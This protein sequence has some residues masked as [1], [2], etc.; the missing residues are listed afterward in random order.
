MTQSALEIGRR[1][2]PSDWKHLLVL[3]VPIFGAMGPYLLP[4]EVAGVNLFA[5][6]ALV[7]VT[8]YLTF[9]ANRGQGLVLDRQSRPFFVLGALW[10]CWAVASYFWSVDQDNAIRE[11]FI[12]CF[13]F[14]AAVSL[15]QLRANTET[16]VRYLIRGWVLAYLCAAA[17][18]VWEFHTGNHLESYTLDN[19]PEYFIARI[20]FSTFATPNNYAAFL[21]LSFPFIALSF[22][23]RG[24]I[25]RVLS[26]LSLATLPFF[27]VLTESR[28]C[29]VG[30]LVQ[31]FLFVVLR[32][33]LNRFLK[34][35]IYSVIFGFCAALLGTSFGDN[36]LS[37]YSGTLSETSAS[38][39][40]GSRRNVS[41][42]GVELVYRTY[43]LGSGAGSFQEEMKYGYGLRNTGG[44]VNPHNF[45]VEIASQYGVLVFS[46]FVAWYFKIYRFALNTYN[47]LKRHHKDQFAFDLSRMLIMALTGYIFAAI[48]N[49][50]YLP[51]SSNWVFLASVV[52]IASFVQN[53]FPGDAK[54]EQPANIWKQGRSTS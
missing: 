41:L 7:L 44:I 9:I 43:G 6:R 54:A 23:T 10:F 21:L 25:F 22:R 46:V 5:L 4:I 19:K 8:L 38:T 13:G 52:V 16:G 36:L 45:F 18:A 2:T 53:S 47:L 15:F 40:A 14:M 31:I 11:A 35:L 50:S 12:I 1:A 24:K 34:L 32:S 3:C 37:K 28:V 29:F 27:M 20:I 51:E 39:S 33:N 42:N 48:A 49:S 26:L 17:V 30:L